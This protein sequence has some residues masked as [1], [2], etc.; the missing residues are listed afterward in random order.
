MRTL[1][2][3]GLVTCLELYKPKAMSGV[4]GRFGTFGAL[5]T[6]ALFT[7]FVTAF[8]ACKSSSSGGRVSFQGQV[9]PFAGLSVDTGPQP[10]PGSATVD[11][12]VTGSG[13]ANANVAAAVEGGQLVGLPGT[14]VFSLNAAVTLAGRVQATGSSGA[15]DEPVPGLSSL[16]IPF[17]GSV[18]FDPFL[19][20]AGQT[21][22]VTTA[23]TPASLGNV[24]LGGT[25]PGQLSLA[26]GD[27]SVLVS[28]LGSACVTV[29]AGTAHYMAETV[30]SGTLV[31]TGTLTVGAP[32]NQSVTL[33]IS[34]LIPDTT[35]IMDLGT[36]PAAGVAD[37]VIGV[38]PP[39]VA[40][41]SAGDASAPDTG[42]APGRDATAGGDSSDAPNYTIAAT[43]NGVSLTPANVVAISDPTDCGTGGYSV[44][45]YFT[46]PGL[47]PNT[48]F[49]MCLSSVMTGCTTKQGIEYQPD[50]GS[51]ATYNDNGTSTCG[52]QVTSLPPGNIV[53]SFDGPLTNYSVPTILTVSLG[54]NTPLTP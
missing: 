41:A 28:T 11:F 46:G 18:A 50:D 32:Y 3:A 40:D 24:P 25:V 9:Q 19:A 7:A 22:T 20:G 26:I 34:I 27:G 44:S 8:G 16:S 31:L 45:L 37:S 54:F 49:G 29:A 23:I 12:T 15:Y 4:T 17:V 2:H 48:R 30:T 42:T 21:A 14:G 13:T 39:P 52:L 10:G 43:V 36:A 51:G 47:G 33:N 53:G 35:E 38:C 1:S 6:L 5:V